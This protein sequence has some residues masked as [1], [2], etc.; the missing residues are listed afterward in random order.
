MRS[1]ID[2]LKFA[3]RCT[4][5]LTLSG[6]A[7]A[8]RAAP[9]TGSADFEVTI[10]QGDT[11][12]GLGRRWLADP[13]RWP[14]LQRHNKLQNPNRLVPGST[15]AIPV[16]LLREKPAVVHVSSVSGQARKADGTPVAA[17]E[18]LREGATITTAQNGYLT[19]Q[20]VDG[21]T[22]R[23]Q[24]NSEL[25]LERARHLP[26]SDAT[27]TRFQMP[28]G[29]AEVRF[30]PGAA[31]TSRFE[32]R[33]GFAS[34]AVRGT[35]FRVG[36]DARGTRT[37]VTA[38]AIAFAG[39]P[40]NA[41]AASPEDA[42]PVAEDYGSIV[43]ESRKP[44]APVRL[45]AAPA[46]PQEPVFQQAPELRLDFP[47][48]DGA[49]G[50]RARLAADAEF[51]QMIGET[52]LSQPQADFSGLKAGSYVLKIRAI[53]RYGLEG[54]DA[55]VIVGILPAQATGLSKSGTPLPLKA[56]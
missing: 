19:I 23:L 44:I 50:Y 42:V 47:P 39:L 37:E 54:R 10:V 13:T 22:L 56:Q 4:L 20:L 6:L 40:P 8:S 51:Q 29:Q 3:L 34:A 16:S 5:I 30:K 24:S 21:S 28:A 55:M 38:G 48:L 7:P 18:R 14:E 26:G 27:Q 17:G 11:L 33:T 12:S 36:A 25:T 35:E 41:G 31:R 1:I 15:L 46:L 2:L 52:V 45:L 43:D 9:D 49:V 53:D 32:I